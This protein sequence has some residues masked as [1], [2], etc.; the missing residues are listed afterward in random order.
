MNQEK[1]VIK[2]GTVID[3]VNHIN[4]IGDVLVAEGKIMS[5][6]SPA[7]DFTADKVIDAAELIVCPGFID[8]CAR[9]REPGETHKA[10][11]ASEVKAAFQSGITTLCCPPDTSPVIDTPAVAE[12]ILDKAQALGMTKVLPIAALTQGLLGQELS[13]MGAL[14]NAGCIA[15]SNGRRELTNT[16]VLRRAMEYAASQDILF[17]CQPNDAWLQHQGCA[18]EGA[19][20]T[21]YG[22]PG[23]PETAETIALV[24]HLVLV[25]LTG[26]RMHFSHLSCA[27]SVALIR[28]AKQEGLPVTADVAIHQLH[29]TEQDMPA[30][31][32][33]YHVIPPFRTEQDRQE[34]RQGLADGTLDAISSDHQPQDEDAKLGAFPETE[35][36]IASLDTL[37]PLAL[38]LVNDKVVSL[39]QAIGLLTHQPAHVLKIDA[40]T[41]T[42]GNP[43]D[44]CIFDPKKTWQASAENWLSHGI[45][46]PF[47]GQELQGKVVQTIKSGQ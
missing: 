7:P 10:S 43:A 36:G 38:E 27:R 15:V 12:L 24:Q 33:L 11:I 13:A 1:I 35:P 28:N 26:C 17:I 8:L 9:L 19:F 44:L 34:L 40:G 41:L 14:K 16:L 21:R 22:L 32:S 18:H 5:V 37:L 45:N 47:F 30:F 23:I 39:E 42:P 6:S 20:A 29:L 3:P 2:G 4:R 46:S 31:D 25:E